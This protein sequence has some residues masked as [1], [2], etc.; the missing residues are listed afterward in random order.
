MER[1]GQRARG[2]KEN[3]GYEVNQG[4]NIMTLE[5]VSYTSMVWAYQK[6]LLHLH[7]VASTAALSELDRLGQI[8][9]VSQAFLHCVPAHFSSGF[10]Q[11]PNILTWKPISFQSTHFLWQPRALAYTK[12]EKK[13]NRK[14]HWAEWPEMHEGIGKLS[15][16]ELKG[17][18][19]S[20]RTKWSTVPKVK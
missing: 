6:K 16:A 18:K 12:W 5:N 11:S 17:E 3:L 10:L 9:A 19:T 8:L 4:N 7:L 15:V 2:K 14:E 20:T 13:I 1:R